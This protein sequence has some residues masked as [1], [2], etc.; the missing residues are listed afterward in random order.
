MPVKTVSQLVIDHV[1]TG[2]FYRELREKKGLSLRELGEMLNL[3]IGYISDLE[4]GRRNWD[5]GL[6]TKFDAI[7]S[8]SSKK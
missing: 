7:L 6:A 2:D 5:E 3:S 8:T 1:R 4:R